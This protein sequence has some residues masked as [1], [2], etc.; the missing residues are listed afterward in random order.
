LV[1]LVELVA[2]EEEK[3]EMYDDSNLVTTRS[4]R[5]T[6]KTTYSHKEVGVSI[7]NQPA[8]D[9]YFILFCLSFCC[10]LLSL[11]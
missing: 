5:V 9:Y 4:G 7:Y 10:L 6:K 2:V 3:E 11:T 1:N 8:L